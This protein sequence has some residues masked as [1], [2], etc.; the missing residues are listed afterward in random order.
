MVAREE[1]RDRKARLRRLGL[2]VPDSDRE[3]DMDSEVA[4]MLERE[5]LVADLEARAL[6]D[7]G[8]LETKDGDDDDE[9]EESS[10]DE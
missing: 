10:D 8:A 1:R 3:S 9:E 5:S 4:E 7:R 2:E 6:G